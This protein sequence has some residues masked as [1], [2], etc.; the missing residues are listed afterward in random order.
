MCVTIV[1]AI[2]S[3]CKKEG[4]E[5]RRLVLCVNNHMYIPKVNRK[6]TVIRRPSISL[7]IAGRGSN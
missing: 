6:S 4:I 5:F 1:I 2:L 3:L 7:R